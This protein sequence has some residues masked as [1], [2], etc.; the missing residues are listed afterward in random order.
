ML[1]EGLSADRWSATFLPS[2]QGIDLAGIVE[3]VGEDVRGFEGR[4]EVP[5][6]NVYPLTE[7]RDAYRKLERRHTRGKIVLRP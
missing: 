1:R 4:L 6:A 3:E 7:V 5:I 2:S